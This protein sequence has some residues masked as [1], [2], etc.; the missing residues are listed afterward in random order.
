VGACTVEV[1]WSEPGTPGLAGPPFAM[2]PAPVFAPLIAD[3]AGAAVAGTIPAGTIPAGAGM[4]GAGSAGG[5]PAP[6]GAEPGRAASGEADHRV[7]APLVGMFY[8]APQ[9][10]APPF[11]EVGD[12][13][14]PGQTLAIVEAMKLMNP[15]VADRRGQ[16]VAIHAADGEVVEY[17]QPLLDLAPAGTD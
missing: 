4:G 9:P 1:E 3:P 12:V 6:A 10:G 7:T 13:V 5:A 14:E 8:R 2:Q 16:V 15:I 11:V 17:D